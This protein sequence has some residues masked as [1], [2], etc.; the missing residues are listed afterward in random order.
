MFFN[1]YFSP[2]IYSVRKYGNKSRISSLHW[3]QSTYKCDANQKI[4]K[5]Y[6]W[7]YSDWKFDIKKNPNICCSEP[8]CIFFHFLIALKSSIALSS[9]RYLLSWE[10]R[11]LQD[12]SFSSSYQRR[13]KWFTCFPQTT[14]LS[15]MTQIFSFRIL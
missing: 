5:N 8:D 1:Y 7:D 13:L 9:T 15:G 2:K 10:R 11:N 3:H 6:S 4:S 12:I 14:G